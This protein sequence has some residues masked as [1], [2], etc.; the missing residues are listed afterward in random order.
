MFH[1]YPVKT[2]SYRHRL[3]TGQLVEFFHRKIIL[4]KTE[5][6]YFPL[7]S[8]RNKAY[9]NKG[10]LSGNIWMTKNGEII[11]KKKKHYTKN[12]EKY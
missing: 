6:F 3:H 10:S 12:I 11:T 7:T 5:S 8:H 9:R 4:Q 1:I 2:V